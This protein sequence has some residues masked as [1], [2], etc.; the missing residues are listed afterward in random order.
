MPICDTDSP[1]LESDD[2]FLIVETRSHSIHQPIPLIIHPT[3]TH[4]SESTTE[5]E[6]EAEDERIQK[7]AT[8]TSLSSIV[9]SA[10]VMVAVLAVAIHRIITTNLVYDTGI[11]QKYSQVLPDESHVTKLE[12]CTTKVRPLLLQSVRSLVLVNSSLQAIAIRKNRSLT[13]Y[14]PN[15]SASWWSRS[16]KKFGPS[17]PNGWFPRP[18]KKFGPNLPSG[19]FPQ[20]LKK[21]GPLLPNGWFPRPLDGILK[22]VSFGPH[23]P[24]GWVP[25][26]MGE[27]LNVPLMDHRFNGGRHQC[28]AQPMVESVGGQGREMVWDRKGGTGE[29]F[30]KCLV[31]NAY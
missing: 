25:R 1:L 27:L 6:D 10:C 26:P 18:L 16:L 21:L 8:E 23:L 12:S 28:E 4:P 29:E 2:D 19:W 22:N 13:K 17:L 7:D 20:P 31:Q 15:Q 5:E 24:C 3:F 11:V 14:D 30:R 9:I